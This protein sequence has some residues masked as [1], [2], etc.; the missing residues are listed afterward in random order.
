MGKKFEQGA[1]SQSRQCC[2]ASNQVP[3][4][5]SLLLSA[6]RLRRGEQKHTLG[7]GASDDGRGERE[8]GRREEG[9]GRATSRRLKNGPLLAAQ[10]PADYVRPP[11]RGPPR[12]W[13][14]TVVS[15][16]L[17]ITPVI[18]R[19]LSLSLNRPD[20]TRRRDGGGCGERAGGGRSIRSVKSNDD[21]KWEE[22]VG[23][24]TVQWQF[25]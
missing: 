21:E 23:S 14:R 1:G 4:S 10:R 17:L 19:A 9:E 22:G 25:N 13:C 20:A 3:S 15:S 18:V 6:M 12:Q 16:Y 8:A 11:V 24:A 5:S 2:T 7:G